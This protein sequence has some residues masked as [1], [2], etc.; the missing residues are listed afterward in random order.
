M[1][2]LGRKPPRRIGRLALLITV[3]L[4]LIT[5]C[6]RKPA[7][8]PDPYMVSGVVRDGGGT[9]IADV[10][11]TFTGGDMENS[12]ATT[13]ADGSWERDGLLVDATIAPAKADHVFDPPHA[14]VSEAR[15]D[16]DFV[17]TLIF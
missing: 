5:S 15:S 1:Y 12:T 6:S 9:G 17:A 11:L 13:G 8:G 10:G 14:T 16:V 7:L 4:F 3:S 2:R